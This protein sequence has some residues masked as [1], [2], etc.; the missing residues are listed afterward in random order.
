MCST[1]CNSLN[2]FFYL[3]GTNRHREKRESETHQDKLNAVANRQGFGTAFKDMP[4]AFLILMKNPVFVL[5]ICGGICQAILINGS[6]A[7]L[8]KFVENE[9][10]LTAER[11]GEVM[12]KWESVC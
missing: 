11:A 2:I 9:F 4:R 5:V 12:G 8:A 6:S 7:F 10:H 1:S 3:L